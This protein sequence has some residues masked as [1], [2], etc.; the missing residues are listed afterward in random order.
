[1]FR[2]LLLFSL[3]LLLDDGQRIVAEQTPASVWFIF[4]LH[5]F[6][7]F[8]TLIKT[9]FSLFPFRFLLM[10]HFHS[11]IWIKMTLSMQSFNKLEVN[12]DEPSTNLSSWLN[13][14]NE[15]YWTIF[16]M[17]VWKNQTFSEFWKNIE[18]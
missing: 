12:K 15:M 7:L 10:A 1:M 2:S 9:Q 3:F 11:L 4:F 16:R 8:V 6:R 17:K 14:W 13:Y 5:Q 18:I